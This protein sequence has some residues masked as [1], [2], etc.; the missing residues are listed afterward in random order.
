MQTGLLPRG[1]NTL[2]PCHQKRLWGFH[3]DC[4]AKM[5]VTG[6]GPM[7]KYLA[8]TSL[9]LASFCISSRAE[10]HVRWFVNAGDAT[11]KTFQFDMVFA[12]VLAGALAFIIT[13]LALNTLAHD[14]ASFTKI[15]HSPFRLPVHIEWQ[16]VSI[17]LGI[18]LL[19]NSH[20]GVL[21]APNLKPD[22]SALA[23]FAMTVQLLLGLLLISQ[24]SY[25]LVAFG[26]S[27][28]CFICMILFPMAL[29]MD[30][31]FEFGAVALAFYLIGPAASRLDPLF[32]KVR[33]WHE[34]AA[35]CTLAVGLG[36]Q[37]VELAVHNKLANPGM[38]LQ[39][40]DDNSYLNFIST[41]G[42]VQFTNIHFAFAGGIAELAFGILLVLGISI[43]FTGLA[44]GL[45]FTLSSMIFGIEEL[46]GHLPIMSIALLLVLRGNQGNL[47]S[48]LASLKPTSPSHHHYGGYAHQNG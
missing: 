12:I 16:L 42:M 38:V 23:G 39:F 20:H 36:L 40:I 30:Y 8:I 27:F 34:S 2:P 41:M 46:V 33:N 22:G 11:V 29:M 17:A 5:N 43:R 6:T 28:L 9:S 45:V 31:I 24:L 7:K 37:L 18:M 4:I 15:L 1:P 32:W 25:R 35:V 19:M 47:I 21:L 48:L 44:V 13:A 10:A 14:N 26:I 3:P